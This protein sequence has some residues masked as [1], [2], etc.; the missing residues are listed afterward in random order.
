[1]AGLACGEVSELAWEILRHGANAAVAVDDAYALE[2]MR[3]LAFPATGETAIVAGETGGTGLA[4]LL[5]ARDYP[6]IR[7]T[8]RLDADSK[9]LLLGSEGDTDPRIYLEVVGRTAEEVLDES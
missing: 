4:A 6:E 2:A 8:L 3:T 5:A 7:A 9:V 1:M